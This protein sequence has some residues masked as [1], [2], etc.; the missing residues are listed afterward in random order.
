M[1]L[2]SIADMITAE[3]A[4]T[5]AKLAESTDFTFSTI[6]DNAVERAK[7]ELY[8]SLP[9][10]AVET[11]IPEI[12]RIWIA[13]K[14]LQNLVPL[15]I[16]F[17]MQQTQTTTK[18]DTTYTIPDRIRALQDLLDRI[19]HRLAANETAALD[20]I[21]AVTDKQDEDPVVSVAGIGIDPVARAMRRGPVPW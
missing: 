18:R 11:D 17:Y 3:W 6:K 10:P 7:V 5:E 12:A 20:A 21:S 1:A 16:D 4:T 13:D 15:G 19:G 2:P 8:G 14:S 9:V